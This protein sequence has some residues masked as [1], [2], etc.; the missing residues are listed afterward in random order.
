MHSNQT[1]QL[2]ETA[3]VDLERLRWRSRR[4]LLELDLILLP[5]VKQAYLRLPAP[6]KLLYRDLLEEEDQ[7]LLGWMQGHLEPPRRYRKLIAQISHWN[8]NRS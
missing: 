8:A 6:L 1:T 5:F 4:G 7:D 2:S 3:R